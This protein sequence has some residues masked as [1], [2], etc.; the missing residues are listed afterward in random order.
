MSTAA[1]IPPADRAARSTLRAVRADDGPDLH[2]LVADGGGL[3]VNSPYAYVL[4]ARFF[5]ATSVIAEGTDGPEGFVLGLAPPTHP[6]TLFVW[7][8][9]VAPA[10]RGRGLG[11][12]MLRWLVAEVAPTHLEATVTPTNTASQRLFGA[13]ARDLSAP[14]NV[15][16]WADRDDLGGAEPE[17]LHRIG[18]IPTS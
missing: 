13:L 8:V 18:P 9:G 12:S 17:D 16:R 6:D 2:A 3:D 7:Q 11:L 1:A 4:A 10:A 14:L 5:G 15:T